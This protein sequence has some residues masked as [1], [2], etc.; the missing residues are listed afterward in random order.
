MTT[1]TTTPTAAGSLTK[2]Q[3]YL[4][5]AA[6]FFAWL[7]AGMELSMFVLA[8]DAA[9][10]DMISAASGAA[11]ERKV[12]GAWFTWY[13]GS[14]MF[15]AAA[16]GWVFGWLGDRFGRRRAM[17]WA[18]LLYSLFTGASYFVHNPW[19]LLALRFVVGM[20]IGGVWP[21]AVSLVAEAWPNA[22]RPFL[23]GVLGTAANAGFILL[24][25][26]G[27]VWLVTADSWRWITVVGTAPLLL[28][29]YILLAV[30]ES[31]KWLAARAAAA[32]AAAAVA[33]PTQPRPLGVQASAAPVAYADTTTPAAVRV[34]GPLAEIFA[35]PL[36]QRTI[37]G[38]LLGAIPLV[39]NAA[40]GNWAVFWAGQAQ[41]SAASPAAKVV[42]KTPA[43]AARL[44]AQT[45]INRSTGGFV[46]SL[47]GGWVTVLLGRRLTYFTACLVYVAISSFLFG[48]LTPEH[49][50]FLPLAFSL[51]LVGNIFFGWLPLYLPELFPTRVRSTGSGV[52]FNSGRVFAAAA[53]LFGTTGLISLFHGDFARVGLWTGGIYAIGMLIIL[54]A[55]STGKKTLED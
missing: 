53:T 19:Q 38:I 51:G 55:P 35:P 25:V 16:G 9:T 48:R 45:Q 11:P 32:A 44:K 41:Q 20:G 12:L 42:K 36:L 3:R 14:V 34:R 27:V 4:I 24:G 15:G 28:G 46:G 37:L 30:P 31:P 7:F 10:I 54:F 5:L 50:L 23:A 22:S 2:A 39:G 47:I 29:L 33:S 1:M 18:V 13:V 52:T 21:N 6:A 43:E 8:G 40:N 17:A 49:D 26:V